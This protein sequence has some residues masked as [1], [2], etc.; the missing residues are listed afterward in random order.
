MVAGCDV[1]G[2]G[3]QLTA[4]NSWLDD[5]QTETAS[6]WIERFG[7]CAYKALWYMERVEVASVWYEQADG[8]GKDDAGHVCGGGIMSYLVAHGLTGSDGLLS[9]TYYEGPRCFLPLADGSIVTAAPSGPN[10]QQWVMDEQGAQALVSVWQQ[11]GAAKAQ[12]AELG[13]EL[14]KG[15]DG[16]KS[17]VAIDALRVALAAD[18]G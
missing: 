11:L 14:A 15:G 4:M 8:S 17:K 16:S 5:Y 18:A 6:W 12:I 1:V 3:S 10:G 9:E 7:R 13:A 2:T